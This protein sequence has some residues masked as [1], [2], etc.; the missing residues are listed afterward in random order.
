MQ[1]QI[2]FES[3]DEVPLVPQNFNDS[4]IQVLIQTENFGQLNL[5]LKQNSQHAQYILNY[6]QE[7]LNSLIYN[8][9][10]LRLLTNITCFLDCNQIENQI[11]IPFLISQTY[12]FTNQHLELAL[13]VLNN[14]IFDTTKVVF[15][16]VSTVSL[17]FLISETDSKNLL[18]TFIRFAINIAQNSKI[19]LE[20]I[21]PL[22]DIILH[23]PHF[24][25]SKTVI[26]YT[27]SL[28]EVL[29][30]QKSSEFAKIF[31]QILPK[32]TDIMSK[33]INIKLKRQFLQTLDEVFFRKF[34]QIQKQIKP[35]IERLADVLLTLNCNSELIFACFSYIYTYLG[36]YQIEQLYSLILSQLNSVNLNIQAKALD[37]LIDLIDNGVDI[38]EN[39][40]D[41][42][43]NIQC[44]DSTILAKICGFWISCSDREDAILQCVSLQ[45]L[46][47]IE[48]TAFGDQNMV[49]VREFLKYVQQY[50]ENESDSV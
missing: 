32:F 39:M 49:I 36:Q 10:F 30:W 44:T 41:V 7:S 14:V 23:S 15:G 43:N 29:M 12:N 17:L 22:L 34:K 24:D 2:D 19:S 3:S 13:T 46:E 1:Q 28:F 48:D 47:R 50:I 20:E 38:D 35:Q 37:C 45:F 11:D 4:D 9:D 42:V 18:I 5:F 26:C 8:V 40:V 25:D 27:L 33:N 31:V 21:S 16:N 6:Y